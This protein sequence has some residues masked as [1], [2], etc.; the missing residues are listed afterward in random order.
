MYENGITVVY[1]VRSD[2]DEDWGQT[3]VLE[4]PGWAAGDPQMAVTLHAFGHRDSINQVEI[5][6]WEEIDPA[7]KPLHA[8]DIQE[9]DLVTWIGI[10]GHVFDGHVQRFWKDGSPR[11]PGVNDSWHSDRCGCH[12]EPWE[13]DPIDAY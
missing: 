12:K 5:Q 2:P 13:Y 3:H 9:G 11:C 7:P 10:N 6:N 4:L 8:T 1:R